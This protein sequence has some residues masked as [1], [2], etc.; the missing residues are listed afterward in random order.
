MNKNAA[1]FVPTPGPVAL[2][3]FDGLE[4]HEPGE[5]ADGDY[6]WDAAV[7]PVPHASEVA[8]MGVDMKNIC[9]QFAATG[10]CPRGEMCRWIHCYL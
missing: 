7:A 6:T 8:W 9:I 5:W 2:P 10:F 4:Y 3:D 1:E